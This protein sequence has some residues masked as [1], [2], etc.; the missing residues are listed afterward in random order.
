MYEVLKYCEGRTPNP[1][2]DLCTLKTRDSGVRITSGEKEPFSCYWLYHSALNAKVTSMFTVGV[3]IYLYIIL[4]VMC[5]RLSVI[6][7]LIM[8]F[9][10]CTFIPIEIVSV[11]ML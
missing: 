6:V 2:H 7:V 3:C 5:G 4:H 11:V 9:Q 1:S 8:P 10:E